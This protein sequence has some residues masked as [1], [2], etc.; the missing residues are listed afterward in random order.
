MIVLGPR[1]PASG[2]ALDRRRLDCRLLAN[3]AGRL[4]PSQDP[5]L[6]EF[7]CLLDAGGTSWEEFF[8]KPAGA[9]AE[10]AHAKEFPQQFAAELARDAGDPLTEWERR[11]LDDYTTFRWLSA[12]QLCS[13]A[14]IQRKVV[15][16]AP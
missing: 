3:V 16:S 8:G 4:Q 10:T 14:E 12:M 1:H 15:R 13:L 7:G 11:F 2:R 6:E 5:A 9:G